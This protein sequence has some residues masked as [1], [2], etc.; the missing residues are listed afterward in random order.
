MD[1]LDLIAAILDESPDL[2]LDYN[3]KLGLIRLVLRLARKAAPPI[4]P[5]TGDRDAA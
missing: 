2:Y 4:V 1:P 5:S 3:T